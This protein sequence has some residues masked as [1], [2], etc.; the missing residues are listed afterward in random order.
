MVYLNRWLSSASNFDTYPINSS[1]DTTGSLLDNSFDFVRPWNSNQINPNKVYPIFIES[2]YTAGVLFNKLKAAD[3]GFTFSG[4]PYVS[5]FERQQLSLAPN[6]DTETVKS[7]ALWADGGTL[8]TF[9]G[10]LETATLQIRVRA[11]NY[12]GQEPYLTSAQDTTQSDAKQNKLL[13]NDFIVSNDYKADVKITGRLLNYR[14]D[15]AQ[16][17]TASSYSSVN[18]KGWNVSGIQVGILKGGVR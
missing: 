6:F 5:Y 12:P 4:T 2:G 17:S 14:V 3:L 1:V 18:T 8:T 16:S 11:T 13:V 9:G 15:D 10:T 7:M